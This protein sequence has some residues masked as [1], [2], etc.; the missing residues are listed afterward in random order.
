VRVGDKQRA[1]D[2]VHDGVEGASGEGGEAER[3]QTD[4]DKSLK[5]PVVAAL[6]GV[7]CGNGSRVVHY[8][9]RSISK[10]PR[11][12]GICDST[13]GIVRALITTETAYLHKLQVLLCSMPSKSEGRDRKGAE[14]TY[15][16]PEQTEATGAGSASSRRHG[17]RRPA[18]R[19]HS[20]GGRAPGGRE[21]AAAEMSAR[22]KPL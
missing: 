10:I 15:W 8:R 5:R 2:G 21:S 13:V 18:R 22:M 6:G 20:S 19:R 7:G 16:F 12:G 14:I 3:N 9:D 4:A 1:Q 11:K 17:K